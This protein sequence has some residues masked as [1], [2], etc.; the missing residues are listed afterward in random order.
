M[1]SKKVQHVVNDDDCQQDEDS[2]PQRRY[3]L[4]T[5]SELEFKLNR[6]FGTQSTM[7][8]SCD[9][10]RDDSLCSLEGDDSRG[11]SLCSLEDKDEE[12]E[13]NDDCDIEAPQL[14]HR[15]SRSSESITKLERNEEWLV[16][17]DKM[18]R[19]SLG[20]RKPL[21]AFVI[22]AIVVSAALVCVI[23][24]VGVTK[25]SFRV[26]QQQDKWKK[27]LQKDAVALKKSIRRKK[28][29]KEYTIVLKGSRL[30][31]IQQSLDAHSKCS[32]VRE[33]QTELLDSKALTFSFN[34][35]AVPLS[36]TFSTDG[37]FLL[38][39]DVVLSCEEIERG[40]RNDGWLDRNCS[41]N[42]LTF[43][44]FVAVLF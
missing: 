40:K 8:T 29:A 44:L 42:K 6:S 25:R 20:K 11:D 12:D 22:Y 27:F 37:V 31:L 14:R 28:P 15:A 26:R 7:S 30:D 23:L 43:W 18:E 13:S 2:N 24:T 1:P 17:E 34:S 10:S 32:S 39:E 3:P 36:D 21:S 19:K 9:D 35:K 38:S 5:P 16:P 33:I 4:G 41:T